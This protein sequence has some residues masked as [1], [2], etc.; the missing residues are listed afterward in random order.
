MLEVDNELLNNFFNTY[1][2]MYMKQ[3]CSP[4]MFSNWFKKAFKIIKKEYKERTYP[5]TIK[6][7]DTAENYNKIIRQHGDEI[8]RIK[9]EYKGVEAKEKL[10]ELL[11]KI[12]KPVEEIT[13]K[14]PIKIDGQ[15]IWF[16]NTMDGI[17]LRLGYKNSD[18]RYVDSLVI[19]GNMVHGK[20]GGATGA[21]KSV[22]LNQI[23][24]AML[25]ELPP[26]E[27]QLTLCDFKF[28]EMV[29]YVNVVPTPQVSQV[30]AC[31]DIDYVLSLFKASKADMIARQDLFTSCNV[32]NLK[33][34]RKKFGMAMPQRLN[35]IDEVQQLFTQNPKMN[36]K[37]ESELQALTK[38]GRALGDHLLFSSQSMKGTLSKDNL[39]NF[40]L[41]IAL[42]CEPD[43]SEMLIGNDR[44]SQIKRKGLAI[45]NPISGT[46]KVEDNVQYR[47]PLISEDGI[48]DYLIELNRCYEEVYN[49]KP[50]T[51]YYD[52][53]SQ[54][55]EK[56]FIDDFKKYKMD[57]IFELGDAVRYRKG[58]GANLEFFALDNGQD[59]DNVLCISQSSQELFYLF[60]LMILNNKY[61][62]P[63]S[64][65]I[66]ISG[67][68]RND[69]VT[70]AGNFVITL[71]SK[72][73]SDLEQTYSIMNMR[74]RIYEL[75]SQLDCCCINYLKEQLNNAN[76]E[77]V[78]QDI[79]KLIT[80][81]RKY[82]VNR[83]LKLSDFPLTNIYIYDA[84]NII[85][86]GRSSKS[87]TIDELKNVFYDSTV[88]NVR[89][90]LLTDSLQEF[91]DLLSGINHRLIGSVV[92]EK[93]KNKLKFYDK[94]DKTLCAYKYRKIADDVIK[95]KKVLLDIPKIEIVRE[96]ELRNE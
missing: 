60:N 35:I 14:E 71:T 6:I 25:L 51:G 8:S 20:L 48:T 78:K 83:R 3:K 91:N 61:I 75:D 43:V 74:K 13:I 15:E 30:V 9:E 5:Y 62:F 88:Y 82:P 19:G 16:G 12:L 87:K 63:S 76:D 92:D 4:L 86:L 73:V 50:F 18:S 38:L 39:A 11:F 23:I 95:F 85:G 21:G 26:W 94:L 68:N 52:E 34:W 42:Y 66:L 45:A 56:A 84:Q 31:N 57:G 46:G 59:S 32:D 80:T 10:D 1:K 36:P 40:K 72:K 33:S 29:R 17:P 69:I 49:R 28:V 54:R 65:N 96:V 93:D 81:R 37:I 67:S 41:G 24:V 58:V 70:K 2:D 47:I 53:H 22:L 89:Y 44:A 7:A 77:Y 79:E 90:Y 64:T 55:K 27:L